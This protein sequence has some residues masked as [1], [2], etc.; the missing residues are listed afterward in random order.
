MVDMIVHDLKT[1]L[2]AIKGTID[3]IEAQGMISDVE[4]AALLDHAG[5]A[6]DFMLLMINDLLDLGQAE[7]AK[8]T[9]EIGLVPVGELFGKI[10]ALFAARTQRRNLKL[11]TKFSGNVKQIK[12]DYSLLFR[13]LVNLVSNAVSLSNSGSEIEIE[14]L[15]DKRFARFIVSDRGPGVPDEDKQRIFEKYQSSRKRQD[16]SG[17]G[18]GIGLSFCKLAAETLGGR[19]WVE[20]RPGGG[21][22]FIAE[23]PL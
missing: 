19:V 17:A 11:K 3:L 4:H 9:P 21:S 18:S 5:T 14:A 8:L 15:G 6:A 12:S 23:L 7:Q 20:D 16:L 1:P 22:L 2:T 13:M 10:E